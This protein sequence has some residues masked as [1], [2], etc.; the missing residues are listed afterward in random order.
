MLP[1]T[2]VEVVFGCLIFVL[3]VAV[4]ACWILYCA[5]TIDR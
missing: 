1:I 4:G 3:G 2:P 5:G